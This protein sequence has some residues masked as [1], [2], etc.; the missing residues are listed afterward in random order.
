MSWFS[1]AYNLVLCHGLVLHMIIY[2]T[3]PCHNTRGLVRTLTYSS[4]VLETEVGGAPDDV[5]QGCVL[6][7][8]E[9]DMSENLYRRVWFL[10]LEFKTCIPLSPVHLKR[11]RGNKCVKY[12]QHTH[13]L[14]IFMGFKEVTQP[15]HTRTR[16]T[17]RQPNT[18]RQTDRQP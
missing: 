14:K 2:R 18:D 6:E 11:T 13:C 7:D 12:A 15:Q 17:G 5:S 1:S 9:R 3:K 16:T 10:V 4:S 8:D